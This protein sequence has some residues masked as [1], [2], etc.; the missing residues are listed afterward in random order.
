MRTSL[1]FERLKNIGLD[2]I[3]ILLF[4]SGLSGPVFSQ[5]GFGIFVE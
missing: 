3:L 2:N 4:F 5:Y 1:T